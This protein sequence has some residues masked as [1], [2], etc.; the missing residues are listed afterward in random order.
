VVLERRDRSQC[1][2]DVSLKKKA[3]EKGGFGATGGSHRSMLGVQL[4]L[5]G[6]NK[7]R[8][9]EIASCRGTGEIA[10]RKRGGM[11]CAVVQTVIAGRKGLG[12]SLRDLLIF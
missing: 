4:V 1:T 10:P 6:R 7:K 11:G 5:W 3:K 2:C 9:G 8:G 12:H